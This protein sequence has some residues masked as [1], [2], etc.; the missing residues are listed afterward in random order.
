VQAFQIEFVHQEIEA[1]VLD[2]QF[3]PFSSL[4]SFYFNVV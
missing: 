4:F 1:R 3:I 2:E